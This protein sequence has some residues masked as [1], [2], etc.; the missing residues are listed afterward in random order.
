MKRIHI[1]TA[2]IKDWDSFHNVFAEAFGFPGFY[3]RNMDAWK[4]Q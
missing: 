3:G 4:I 2:R 1:D